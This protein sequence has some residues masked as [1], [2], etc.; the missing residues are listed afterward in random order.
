MVSNTDPRK[1]FPATLLRVVDVGAR[2]AAFPE[3]TGLPGVA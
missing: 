3:P 1:K 2:E